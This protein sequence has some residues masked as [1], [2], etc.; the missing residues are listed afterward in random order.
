MTTTAGST[1]PVDRTPP[2]DPTSTTA[3]AEPSLALPTFTMVGSEADAGLCVD[4][5]CAVP[6]PPADAP[7]ERVGPTF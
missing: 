2:L 7:T 3:A 1:P 6:T 4:G 5:V